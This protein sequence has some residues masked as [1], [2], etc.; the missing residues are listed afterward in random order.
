MQQPR[1][2]AQAVWVDP[3]CGDGQCDSPWEFAS[4]SSFGCR[5]DCGKLQD[6]QNLTSIQIDL[7]WNF[8]HPLGSTPAAVSARAGR[9]CMHAA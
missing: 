7:K 2:P 6:V 5:A 4:F 9:A 3:V 8:G 1:T